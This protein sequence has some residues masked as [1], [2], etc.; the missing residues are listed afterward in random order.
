[1][2]YIDDM[3]SQID[4]LTGDLQAALTENTTLK[5]ENAALQAEAK[6]LRASKSAEISAR[7]ASA[8]RARIKNILTR[9]EAEGRQAQARVFAFESDVPETLAA[10]LLAAQPK[11]AGASRIPSIAERAAEMQEQQALGR[12]GWGDGI[13]AGYGGDLIA[14]GRA[15]RDP[16]AAAVKN[17]NSAAQGR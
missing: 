6:D 4:R 3:R 7:A 11:E 14:D 2:A 13:G 9:P 15:A 8:E 1:M 12:A 5:T 17:I 16:L 10:Q